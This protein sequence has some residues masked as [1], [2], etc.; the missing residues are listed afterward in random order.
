MADMTYTTLGR[1]G[2]RIPRL[3]LGGMSFGKPSADFHQ[4]TIGP[5]ET[6]AVI[7][8]AL[9]LGVNFIDTANCYAHGTS[10]EYIGAAL[11]ELGIPRDQVVLASKV[12]FNEGGLSREAINREIDGTLQRLGT[13]YLDL[14]IIHRFDYETPMEE[15]MEALDGLV[16]AGKVRALGASAMYAY[17]LHNMQV[18]AEKNGWTPFTSMQCHY[19][20]LYREDE[21]E[22]IPVCRQYDMALTPYSP[23]ASGHLCRPTWESDSAR[24][25]TDVVVRNKYD[26]D[27]ERDMPIV[28]RVAELAER[29]G[30]PMSRIAL[31]W[32][33]AR[34][35]EAPIVGCSSPAR[36]DDAVAALDVALTAEEV[37]YLEEPYVAH[38]LVGPAARPGEKPL[39]GTTNPNAK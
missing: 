11:R 2:I 35:V 16:R 13:D 24:S 6:R 9:E 34:G 1:S 27:R 4:W 7:A 3:C 23:L 38:E 15:T 17:Q 28:E 10:E 31:A 19:N 26:A 39:A 12:F 30:V 22:M 37:A 32:H 18:V 5:D 36:V 33:W 25:R 8:R 20:L 29:H 21:R 14:Y